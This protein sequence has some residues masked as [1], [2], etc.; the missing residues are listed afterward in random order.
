LFIDSL[1]PF[2][3]RLRETSVTGEIVDGDS[4][5]GDRSF[6]VMKKKKCPKLQLLAPSRSATVSLFLFLTRNK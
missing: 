5:G 1:I 2:W 4:G 3:L 6:G